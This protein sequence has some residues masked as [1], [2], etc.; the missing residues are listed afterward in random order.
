[1]FCRPSQCV[2]G[3]WAKLQAAVAFQNVSASGC[4]ALQ[5]VIV[6]TGN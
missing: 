3:V 2:G 5:E 1:M 4:L 6:P